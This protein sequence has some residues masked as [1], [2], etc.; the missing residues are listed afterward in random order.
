MCI[1]MAEYRYPRGSVLY[2]NMHKSYPLIRSGRGAF[3]YDIN[4]KKYLDASGGAAVVNIGHGVKEI[5]AALS[6]QARRAA[7]VNGLQFT[8]EPVEKLAAR[9][10][11]FL[12]FP[13][14]KVF[15]LTSGSEAIE[16]SIKLARQ[17]WIERGKP[18]KHRVISLNPS[19]HG[20][21][22]AALA[23]SARK[24][25]QEA[26]RPLLLKSARVPAPYC[27]RC[28]WSLKPPG[29]GVKCAREVEKAIRKIG[30]EKVSAF[31]GEV[32]GGSSTG[33][34]VP[35]QE[36]WDVIRRVC[37]R[38]EALL[39]V[40]EVMTGAGRT[41]KWL[42]CHHYGLVPDIVVMGKGLTSGY[43][44]LSV[45][46]AKAAI[47]D[48][49]FKQG[50]NFLHA[51]TFAHHA[52]G[53]AAGLAALELIV[54]RKLV[55]ACARKGRR[56]LAELEPLLG[57]PHVGDIRGK[58]LLIGIEFVADKRKKTPFPRTVKY[59]ER[60]VAD[61]LDRGLVLWPNVGQAD[62]EKGDLVMIAPLFTI[63]AREIV[64]IR[65][66]L[67]ESLHYMEGAI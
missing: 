27:Y 18:E 25:Y 40:D 1:A 44:P 41:G 17:Y 2:R 54:E 7:Y 50:K 57:H 10:A 59:A 22:L 12:P 20:N 14:G 39:I 51:Q 26:F 31:I 9:V 29:C 62:G 67:E 28:P 58:G 13:D 60:F 53:C 21:T 5:A 16:A 32:V 66:R 33:A 19:Y 52:V 42:A 34:S 3:L 56:L 61:A 4:G 23:L 43:F 6:R 8:H 38:N 47:L 24:H 45:V 63:A 11:S 46:A 55:S 65:K 15:F 48:L 36:Y 37:D 64:L 30:L 35:P 49:I